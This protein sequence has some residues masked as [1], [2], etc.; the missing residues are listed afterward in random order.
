MSGKSFTL[1]RQP[2]ATRIIQQLQETGQRLAAAARPRLDA[3]ARRTSDLAHS[4]GDEISH[5]IAQHRPSALTRTARAG[6]LASAGRISMSRPA[7][8]AVGGLALAGIAIAIGRRIRHERETAE[9]ETEELNDIGE[10]SYT[11][12]RQAHTRARR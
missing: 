4:A 1:I 5:V 2:H 3:A 8:L 10:G 11:A 9:A 7:L 12:G 6:G